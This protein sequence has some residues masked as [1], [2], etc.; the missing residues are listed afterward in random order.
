M[1]FSDE[2]RADVFEQELEV[3]RLKMTGKLEAK[4]RQLTAAKSIIRGLQDEVNELDRIREL[5]NTQLRQEPAWLKP[6]KTKSRVQRGTA[7]LLLSDLHLDEY[8]NPSEMMGRNAFSREI[9]DMRLNNIFNNFVEQLTFYHQGTTYDGVVV[10]LGGDTVNGDIHEG[11]EHNQYPGPET[12]RYWVPKLAAGLTMLADVFGKVHVAAVPGNHGRLTEK[13]VYKNRATTNFDW[14]IASLL[15]QWFANDKRFT[16]DV[17][18][19]ME[20]FLKVY[21]STILL[22]H[23]DQ[24]Q[25]G[26]GV[27]GVFGTLVRLQIKKRRNHNFDLLVCGHFHQYINTQ[28]ILVNNTMK[29]WDEYALGH[30]FEYSEPAQAAFIMTPE[31]SMTWPIEIFCMDKKKEG[32]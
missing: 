28:G 23:G 10:M 27:L 13:P 4:S 11:K 16:F 3:E 8:V 22:T 2:I 29:G 31:H 24:A 32:W 7:C 30:S 12:V 6:R 9:A 25:G 18:Q 15:A 19:A 17:P 5:S 1:S 14:L 26:S 20:T 21:D